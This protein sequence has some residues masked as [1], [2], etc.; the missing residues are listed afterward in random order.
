M[1]GGEEHSVAT[2]PADPQTQEET[3]FTNPPSGEPWVLS[4][5]DAEAVIASWEDAREPGEGLK[6]A[7][8]QYLE[9]IRQA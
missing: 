4:P 9:M 5:A 6:A 3:C 1:N 7:F 2:N 8:E